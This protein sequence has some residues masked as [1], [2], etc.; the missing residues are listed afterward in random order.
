MVAP[1][2]PENDPRTPSFRWLE[3][4][5]AVA[6]LGAM[7]LPVLLARGETQVQYLADDAYYYVVIA[8]NWAATGVPTFDGF[9]PTSGFHLAFGAVMALVAKLSA[10]DALGMGRAAVVV[11]AAAVAL[12]VPVLSGALRRLCGVQPW[13]ASLALLV[14]LMATVWRGTLTGVE[15]G[16][17]LLGA[18]LVWWAAARIV[19]EGR[20]AWLAVAPLVLVFRSDLVLLLA[21]VGPWVAWRMARERRWPAAACALAWPVLGYGLVGLLFRL[22]TGVSGQESG[23][24]KMLWGSLVREREA[25]PVVQSLKRALAYAG[26]AVA[27]PVWPGLGYHGALVAGALGVL[28]IG[29][30]AI[31]AARR[32]R[33][34]SLSP[35]VRLLAESAAAAVLHVAA[36]AV[37]YAWFFTTIQPHW[38]FSTVLP[39]VLIVWVG[40]ARAFVPAGGIGVRVRDGAFAIMIVSNLIAVT[41]RPR[42]FAWQEVPY[43]TAGTLFREIPADAVVGAWNAGI[44][45][46]FGNRRVVNLDGLVNREVLPLARD[47]RVEELLAARGITW[48]ADWSG[49]HNH[50]VLG[51]LWTPGWQDEHLRVHRQVDAPAGKAWGDDTAYMIWRV[52]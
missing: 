39:S 50:R 9:A 37:F 42:L 15:Y 51:R 49:M 33:A 17:A 14:P 21:A 30:L 34:G 32:L 6:I 38:Y 11:N 10:W 29:G 13:A 16:L 43:T 22:V 36:F 19:V 40:A 8:R 47:R 4:V 18:S 52:E 23:A 7:L 41:T 31:E 3:Y 12:A 48:V 5:G 26:E 25:H 28:L 1:D 24:T 46:A 45:A 20:L 2:S 27:S 44:P 35:G